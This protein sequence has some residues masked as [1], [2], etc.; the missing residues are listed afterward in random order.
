MSMEKRKTRSGTPLEQE[1][2]EPKEKSK[3]W[4]QK[5]LD[6]VQEENRFIGK[7]TPFGTM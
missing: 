6:M 1:K 3:V 2:K 7:H 5:K 4:N